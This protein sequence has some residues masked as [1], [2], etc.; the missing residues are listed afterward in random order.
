MPLIWGFNGH[1]GINVPPAI[2]AQGE[3]LDVVWVFHHI[4]PPWGEPL[5]L[6]FNTHTW[7]W[8]QNGPAHGADVMW[9]VLPRDLVWRMPR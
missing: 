5:T 7:Q 3:W 8:Y 2:F 1:W 4:R 9:F 6:R